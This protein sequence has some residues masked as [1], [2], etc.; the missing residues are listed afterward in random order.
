MNTEENIIFQNNQWKEGKFDTFEFKRDLFKKVWDDLETKLIGLIT[1]PRRVGKSVL[2]KQIANELIA[3]KSVSPRQ[4]LFYEFSP[5]DSQDVIWSVFD[6][7]SKE[8]CDPRLPIY[9]FFDE[10]QYVARYESMV[11]NIYD[12]INNCKIFV[13]GSLSL[14]YKKKMQESLAGRFFSY[15]LYP[16]NFLEFIK[17]YKLASLELYDEVKKEKDS[18]K[19]TYLLTQLNAD[20]RQFLEKGRY[21]ETFNLSSDQNRAYLSNIINQSLNQDAYSYFKIEKP[22]VINSLFDYIRQNNGGLISFN[23]IADQMGASNQTIAFY[24][25]ILVQM[26]I[27]YV[28]Y[29]SVNPLS[30]AQSS[31]KVYINSSF[32]LL[33]TKLDIQTATGFAVE[34]YVL[35]KLLEKGETVTFWRKREKEVDF[36][37]PDKRIGYEVKFRSSIPDV[38][39]VIKD[40]KIEIISLSGETPACLF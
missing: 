4:I 34:S 26:G 23:K 30:K 15:K 39:P 12:N 16:L 10:I 38:K 40:Y 6:Y 25:D 21:P 27:V 13:T 29:N 14:T 2:L 31:K 36:L 8:I 24:L 32:A 22:T 28:V 1:G 18:I 5:N 33:D 7:F 17:L 35:E 19:K 3:K 37:I 11:K 20:F 9:I